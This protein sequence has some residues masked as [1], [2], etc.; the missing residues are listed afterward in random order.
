M[1]Y[2]NYSIEQINKDNY[3][4]FVEI[5][6]SSTWGNCMMPIAY[7]NNLWG[8]VVFVNDTIVGGWC[9]ILRGNGKVTRFIAKSVYFDSY[10]IFID[11]HYLKEYLWVL[12]DAVKKM[13]KDNGIIMLHLTHW[14]RGQFDLRLTNT[15]PNATFVNNLLLD[16]EKIMKGMETMKQRNVK[17]A[18]KNGVL[19]EH[20]YQKEGLT[21]LDEFQKLREQTQVRAIRKNAQSSMLL[22]S[23]EFFEHL[24][25]STQNMLWLAKYNGEIV[26]VANLIQSGETIYYHMG[27]SNK[28]VNRKTAASTLLFWEAMRYYKSQGLM[29]FDFGGSPLNPDESD[30]AY[31]VYLFKKGFGG[32]LM[33]NTIGDIVINPWKYALLTFVLKQRW[34]IRKLSKMGM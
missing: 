3:S 15:K 31:G 17:K 9:G 5:V 24:F 30:P 29:N 4:A 6:S 27:G 16:E 25:C 22:K 12:L 19:V 11:D 7:K 8:A 20:Y 28:D 33:T 26:S 21:Y 32:E 34:L 2:N 13:A 23:N 18:I 1:E 14:V 10:P